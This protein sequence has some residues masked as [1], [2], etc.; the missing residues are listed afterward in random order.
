MNRPT[1][2]HE[3]ESPTATSLTGA[4]RMLVLILVA[5]LIASI[6]YGNNMAY[7][8][9]FLLI[10]LMMIAYLSTR[11]NLKGLH[12][13]NVLAEPVFAGDEQEFIFEIYNGTSGRRVSVFPALDKTG[14]SFDYF[15]P[16]SVE[17]YSRTT[18]KL[19]L[20]APKRGRYT[21]VEITLV[22]LY[23]LGLFKALRRVP[24]QK[25]YLVYPQPMGSQRWPEPEIH[26]D[27]SSESFVARGGDDFVGVHP[28]RP[29]ES[30]RHIDWK[31][32][33]RGRPL[34]VKE[35]IGGGTL[36]QWFDWQQLGHLKLEPR[37]SQLT[38]WVLEADQEGTEF[39]L[40]L[41]DIEIKPDCSPGHTTKCLETLALY[42]FNQ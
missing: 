30:M 40:R 3:K 17:A 25:V 8:L 36:Q 19:S 26:E 28:Y 2:S 41:P 15:G 12:I 39:G 10:G 22:S 6:N 34:T 21:L 1:L 7:I 13:A 20:I 38:R 42:R 14:N 32:Y 23:P 18:S 9:C 29:G 5:M 27:E 4:G 24:V 16:Y 37:I 35:F 11:N 33:A 31:A